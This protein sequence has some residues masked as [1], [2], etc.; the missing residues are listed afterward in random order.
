MRTK[1]YSIVLA[2]AMMAAAPQ[3]ADAQFLKNLGKALEKAAESKLKGNSSNRSNTG[4]TS[5][6]ATG[7]PQSQKA[8]IPTPHKTSATKSMTI[9]GGAKSLC[10]FSCGVALVG[11]K[12]GWFV[13]NKKGEKLF[14]LPEGYRPAGIDL[15]GDGTDQFD[16]DRLA[17]VSSIGSS[18]QKNVAIIDIQGKIVKELGKAYNITP[19]K[20]GLAVL[21]KGKNVYVD[22]DGREI[23]TSMPFYDRGISGYLVSSLRE[24]R[25]RFV[26]SQ[27]SKWGYCDEN[28]QIVIPAIFKGAGGFYNGLAQA[29]NDDGLWG[30]INTSGRW[31]IQPEYSNVPTPFYGPYSL[32]TDKSGVRYYMDKMGNIVWKEPNPKA[33]NSYREFLSTG[34]SVYVKYDAGLAPATS[35]I[36]IMDASF[37]QVG[38]VDRRAVNVFANGKIVSYNEKWFQ[39][40]YD[41][42][43]NVVFDWKGNALLSF[44]SNNVFCED[45]CAKDNY[46]FNDKGEIIIQFVDTQF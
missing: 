24:G 3:Q 33:R 10:P 27:K 26:D 25:R 22:G 7:K 8:E 44:Y 4:N 32:V 6:S 36:I 42:S 41:T 31:I 17:I 21:E 19:L 28:S 18:L 2:F 13:I 35:P 34:Y 45:M 37:N 5:R 23:T 46:Y 30:F 38:I 20:D 12:K 11:H 39:W 29:K 43:K 40:Q 14:D 15:Y 1:I 9:R 16:H